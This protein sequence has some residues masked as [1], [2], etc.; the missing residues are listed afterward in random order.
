MAARII[1][2]IDDATFDTIGYQRL[3]RSAS[4]LS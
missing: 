4:L 3:D 1:P 2:Q